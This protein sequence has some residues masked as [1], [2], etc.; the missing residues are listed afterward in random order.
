MLL[1]KSFRLEPSRMEAMEDCRW[2]DQQV[3]LPSHSH[4]VCVTSHFFRPHRGPSG[5]LLLA[6][7]LRQGLGARGGGLNGAVVAD[8][9]GRRGGLTDN[10]QIPHT[11][12]SQTS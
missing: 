5:S 2:L 6:C 1:V 9:G 10:H 7:H 3:L 11:E 12:T 4:P 8:P